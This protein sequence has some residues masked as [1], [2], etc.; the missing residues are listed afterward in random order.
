MIVVKYVGCSGI[1]VS[2]FIF[3]ILV[4]DYVFE[5]VENVGVVFI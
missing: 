3:W 1:D 4:N 5:C 2:N